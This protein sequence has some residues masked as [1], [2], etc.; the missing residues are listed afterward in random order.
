RERV[1]LGDIGQPGLG[2]VAVAVALD[3]ATLLVRGEEAAEGDDGA[4]GAEDGVT[5][6]GGRRP[7]ADRRRRAARVGQLGGDGA[8]PDQLVQLE[9]V[10]R[11]LARHLTRGAERVTGGTDRL[12]RLL[13]ALGGLAVDARLLRDVLGA[14]QLG[15][16]PA[17]GRG[18]LP[19]PRRGVGAH[20][21][22]VAVL[23]Q[24]LR[25]AHRLVGAP[26]QL[27]GG[28]LLQGRRRERRGRAARVRLG[29]DRAHGERGAVE[30]TDQ[31]GRRRLVERDD[32]LAAA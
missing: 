18:G 3:V 25:G 26:P 24:R 22:D 31:R 5:A 6:V 13:R 27:A 4:R 7:Q 2:V 32:L 12:V 11:E 17:R 30:R 28:L 20:V 16:L 9:L 19:R 23:V 15:R 21:R 14:V 1:A 8:L 29:L 10:A